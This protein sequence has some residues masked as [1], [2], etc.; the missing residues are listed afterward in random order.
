MEREILQLGNPLLYEVS[1]EVKREELDS[2]KPVFEDMFDCIRE[3]A[4][5][6]DSDGQLRHRRLV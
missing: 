3:S 5:I 4:G 1:E 6:M 2:L